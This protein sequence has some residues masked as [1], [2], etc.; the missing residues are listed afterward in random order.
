MEENIACFVEIIS[1]LLCINKLYGGRFKLDIQTVI[2]I[3]AD[4]VLIESVNENILPLGMSV[5]SYFLFIGYCIIE[6]GSNKKE[7]VINFIMCAIIIS[8]L[9][10]CSW[11]VLDILHLTSNN[12]VDAGRNTLLV[13]ILT[14]ALLLLISTKERLH[15]MS[16]FMQQK[17]P[18]IR[19]LLII[20]VLLIGYLI[21]IMKAN[22][23]LRPE[24]YVVII[25]SMCLLCIVT[26]LWQKTQNKVKEQKM[27]L[28][29]HQLYDESY[30]ELI[31][32]IRRKQHDFSNHLNTIT[33]MGILYDNYEELV[34][35]QSGYIVSL[36][37]ENR[38]SKLLSLGDAVIVGFLYSKFLQAEQR[39]IRVEYELQ[40]PNMNCRIP[41]HKIVEI[42]GN[43]FDNAM[44]AVE[45]NPVEK[46]IHVKIENRQEDIMFVIYNECE[47][48]AQT[49]IEKMFLKGVSSKGENRGLG[50]TNVRQICQEY[51]CDLEVGNRKED[52]KNYIQFIVYLK[53]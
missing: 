26:Y 18:I 6:F 25:I 7:L 50:L 14:L 11:M 19:T 36:K 37:E 3:A 43:L 49:D 29:M 32:S 48:L 30:N 4:M 20:G 28:L 21:I 24:H 38:Y 42:I 22:G 51:H 8:I 31:T 34:E 5:M 46:V 23:K 52:D 9:Q 53:K 47:H 10:M 39:K 33:S 13:M 15:K 16:V 1:I 45:Q 44:D 40:S 27:E 2:I 35:N 17:F 12:S 41:D